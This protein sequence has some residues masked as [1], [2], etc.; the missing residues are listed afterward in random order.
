MADIS[1]GMT[2]K[3]Y[4]TQPVGTMVG[5]TRRVTVV[6]YMGRKAAEIR[7]WALVPTDFGGQEG[8]VP[9]SGIIVPLSEVVAIRKALEAIELDYGLTDEESA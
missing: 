5:K 1:G 7:D 2:H 4:Y 6:E 9:S 8:E 3:T